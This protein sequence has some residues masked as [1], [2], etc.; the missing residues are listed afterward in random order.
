MSQHWKKIWFIDDI[1]WFKITNSNWWGN[2]KKSFENYAKNRGYG[3]DIKNYNSHKIDNFIEEIRNN[4]PI[5]SSFSAKTASGEEWG[6]AVVT[7]GYEK[8][9]HTYQVNNRYWLFGWHDK[10]VTKQDELFYLRCIDGWGT[11]N[12]AQF[13]KFDY[14][15]KQI[16][17]SAFK[18]KQQ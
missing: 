3:Y 16:R 7:V 5:F 18:L 13:L 12:E 11:A 1:N 4:K 2:T 9:T 17:A 14:Q 8:F 15:Y 10:W 6:Y